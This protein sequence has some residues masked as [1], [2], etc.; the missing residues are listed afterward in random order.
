MKKLLAVLA[1]CKASTFL[2]FDYVA[3]PEMGAPRKDGTRKIAGPRMTTEVSHRQIIRLNVPAVEW[4][5]RQYVASLSILS[6]MIATDEMNA[7]AIAAEVETIS[8]SLAVGIGNHPAY[9]LRDTFAPTGIHG[10]SVN[11]K[12]GDLSVLG[13]RH[14][15]PRYSVRGEYRAT[16]SKPETVARAAVVAQLPKGRIARFNLSG[17]M[18]AAVSGE[19]LS[20]S[21][22]GVTL[23]QA[24]VTAQ[25]ERAAYLTN[26]LGYVERER[27]GLSLGQ[28]TAT[29][30][31]AAG[32]ATV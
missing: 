31:A 5:E 26:P 29:G 11:V 3:R 25:D 20:L 12:T 32:S 10:V 30:I 24:I 2:G 27:S 18:G 23:A 6:Q 19:V 16:V 13:L 22:D 4:L 21:M 8:E 1:A 14:G 17:I 9:R 7:A 28:L 15:S